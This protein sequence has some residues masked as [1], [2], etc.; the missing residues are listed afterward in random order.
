M[1]DMGLLVRTLIPAV[2]MM[3]L[4]MDLSL[5]YRSRF[6]DDSTGEDRQYSGGA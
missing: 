3:I 5:L 4:L 2:S 1:L 6:V